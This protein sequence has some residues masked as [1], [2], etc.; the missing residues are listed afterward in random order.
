MIGIEKFNCHDKKHG[1]YNQNKE[2]VSLREVYR[3]NAGKKI[4][5]FSQTFLF[6]SN[7]TLREP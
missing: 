4:L 6:I 1:F 5:Q 2:K 3:V 7:K